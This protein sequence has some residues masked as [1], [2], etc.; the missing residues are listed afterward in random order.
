MI[1]VLRGIDVSLNDGIRE[2][3]GNTRSRVALSR[4]GY[5]RIMLLWLDYGP[6][7]LSHRKFPNY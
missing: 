7:G 1:N 2:A 5:Q 4:H 6:F 3:A